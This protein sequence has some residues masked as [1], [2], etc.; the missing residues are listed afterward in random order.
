MKL[1]FLPKMPKKQ[2]QQPLGK[3]RT[4]ICIDFAQNLIH[5]SNMTMG[6]PNSYRHETAAIKTRVFDDEFFK[7]FSEIL[8]NYAKKYPVDQNAS[9]TVVLPNNFVSTN[10]VNLPTMGKKTGDSLNVM[11][12]ELYKNREK[13][14][15]NNA[16]MLQ[17]KQYTTYAISI[18]NQDLLSKLYGVC[19]ENR[20]TPH[21]ITFAANAI[22]N[23]VANLNNALSSKTYAF[24]DIKPESGTVILVNK[25]RTAG[26]YD[27]PFGYSIM[28]KNRLA[29]ENMLFDFPE[30]D[31][32]VLNAMEKAKLKK[33]TMLENDNA[34]QTAQAISE[35]DGEQGEVEVYDSEL[36][37]VNPDAIPTQK[38]L[39]K[40]VPLRLPKF[41]T[42]PM[43]SGE[44]EYAY[45][46]F[47]IL[48]KWALNI[49][50]S[51]K[52]NLL[53]PIDKVFVNLPAEFDYIFEMTNSEQEENGCEFVRFTAR[54]ADNFLNNMELYGGFFDESPN[55]SNDF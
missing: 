39:P 34:A 6:E 37:R 53:E 21:N 15:I 54:N 49:I 27:L 12:G 48:I 28:Q 26:F 42:R 43:P 23:G 16:V 55:Y 9:A 7:K 2:Q 25:G 3:F 8:G 18:M 52:S 32:L 35:I 14:K 13:L 19:A 47:R 50:A 33:L 17:N 10:I 46:N 45:E 11:L 44:Q 31:L 29:A 20:M 5:L 36:E 22:I 1:E 41:M 24:L 4:V 30:A 40:K 51:N 38:V